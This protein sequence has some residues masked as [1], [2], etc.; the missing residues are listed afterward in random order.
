MCH[1]WRFIYMVTRSNAQLKEDEITE[2]LSVCDSSEPNLNN[3]CCVDKDES[4]EEPRL[5]T[6]IKIQCIFTLQ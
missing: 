2:D 4:H 3:F 5:D 1:K 6:L